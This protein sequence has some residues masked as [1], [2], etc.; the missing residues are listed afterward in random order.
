MNRTQDHNQ[1]NPLA[2]LLYR[3]L[4]GSVFRTTAALSMLL[5][6]AKAL[7]H[8]QDCTWPPRLDELISALDCHGAKEA[9]IECALSDYRFDLEE[10]FGLLWLGLDRGA[11]PSVRLD[12]LNLKDAEKEIILAIGDQS[13]TGKQ[14]AFKID[15]D[16]NS[17]EVRGTLSVLRNTRGIL[18]NRRRGY[19]VRDEYRW[20]LPALKDEAEGVPGMS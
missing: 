5:I 16:P 15:R 20:L 10:L 7:F 11:N 6:K 19:F 4:D 9:P 1:L 12:S 18:E 17:S 3:I 2:E 13:L 8:E 14:I